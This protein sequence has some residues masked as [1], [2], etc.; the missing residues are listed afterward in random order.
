MKLRPRIV[1]AM[2]AIAIA[3]VAVTISMARPGCTSV[4][5]ADELVITGHLL[6]K[7]TAKTFCYRDE[8]GKNLRFVLA[9]GADGKVRSVMDACEQCYRY[10]KGFNYRDGYLIC[11]QCGNRYKVDDILRGQASCVPVALPSREENGQIIVRTAD[12]RKNGYLF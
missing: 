2:T 11:R 8:A 9:R 4:S 3:A 1:L 6:D 12:L 7:G 10:H 5:G